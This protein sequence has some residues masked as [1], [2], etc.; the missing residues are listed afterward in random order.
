MNVMTIEKVD[1][2]VWCEDIERFQCGVFNTKEWVESVSNQY[3]CAVFFNFKLSGEVVGKL[4]G[5]WVKQGRIKGDQLFFYTGPALKEPSQELLNDCC[6]A[7]LDFARVECIQ[8][9]IIGS[10]DQPSG[11][12]CEVPDFYPNERYEFVVDLQPESGH[13]SFSQNLKRNVKKAKKLKAVLVNRDDPQLIRR[14]I[15]LLNNTLEQRVSKYGKEY[16]PFYLPYMDE[17]CLQRLLDMK[18]GKFYLVKLEG[19]EVPHSVLFNI[20]VGGRVF[21]LLVGSDNLAYQYGLAAWQIL[22]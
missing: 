5:L 7:L 18:V 1:A 3:H 13:V 20:E 9:V 11:L 16:D 21:N 19:D 2:S 14:L 17:S 4:A 12:V 22:N 10:Y 6:G 15:E 8:R